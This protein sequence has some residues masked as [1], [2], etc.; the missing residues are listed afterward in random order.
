MRKGE[1]SKG[2][3]RVKVGG[4]RDEVWGSRRKDERLGRRGEE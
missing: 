3:G 4:S 1:G 2:W